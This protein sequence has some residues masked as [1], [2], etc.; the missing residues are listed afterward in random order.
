MTDANQAAMMLF[1]PFAPELRADPYPLYAKLREA[2]PL[3][4][5]PMG[6]WMV[7][8]YEQVDRV[9]RSAAFRTPRGYRD[10]NDPAGPGRFATDTPLALHRRHWLI[11]QSGDAH[12]RLRK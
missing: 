11:F 4:K 8:R 6:N 5:T 12:T 9:L 10:A 7:T 2:A 1:N 3:V